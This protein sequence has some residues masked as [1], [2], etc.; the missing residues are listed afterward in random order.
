MSV[1]NQNAA[2][3]HSLD[4]VFHRLLLIGFLL[5]CSGCFGVG[6]DVTVYGVVEILK[7][8]VCKTANLRTIVLAG[9][10][11]GTVVRWSAAVCFMGFLALVLAA[12]P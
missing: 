7:L 3:L 9:K 11:V 4:Y 6:F 10:G 5:L 12:V 8:I 1:I 2:Q